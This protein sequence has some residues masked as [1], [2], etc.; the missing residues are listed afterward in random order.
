M[1]VCKAFVKIKRECL[2]Q[3]LLTFS[4]KIVAIIKIPTSWMVTEIDCEDSWK[5]HTRSQFL[6]P[7][8]REENGC[9]WETCLTDCV[10]CT[11]H[12][13][14]SGVSPCFWNETG[15]PS[16]HWPLS[17]LYCHVQQQRLS[18]RCLQLWE[19][20]QRG[21]RKMP[22]GALSITSPSLKPGECSLLQILMGS[23]SSD[24]SRG[25]SDTCLISAGMTCFSWVL[26]ERH[27]APMP[28]AGSL[29]LSLHGLTGPDA[30]SG[31]AAAH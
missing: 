4:Y 13:P 9:G 29:S 5:V 22:L 19:M 8:R 26:W 27:A 6:F 14:V 1:L 18:E 23:I 31:P 3:T 10:S 7:H 24:F 11:F 28:T 20:T 12:L 2:A 16:H 17:F 30:M 25:T 15:V 21:Q